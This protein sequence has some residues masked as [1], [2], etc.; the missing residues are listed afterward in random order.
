MLSSETTFTATVDNLRL[1]MV[2]ARNL[3][4]VGLRQSWNILE[5]LCILCIPMLNILE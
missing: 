3:E 4:M 2:E 1:R 5:H